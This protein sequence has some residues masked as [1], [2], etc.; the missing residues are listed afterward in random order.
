MLQW[1]IPPEM[2]PMAIRYVQYTLSSNTL[3]NP[4][5]CRA[6]VASFSVAVNWIAGLVVALVSPI[7]LKAI[8]FKYFYVFVAFPVAG[9]VVYY[10]FIPE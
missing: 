5:F 9:S 8:A 7:A 3:L 6:K 1:M 4:L 2:S 10:F